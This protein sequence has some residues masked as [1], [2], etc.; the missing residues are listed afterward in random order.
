VNSDPPPQ[1]IPAYQCPPPLR[2]ILLT[3]FSPSD[4]YPPLTSPTR[5]SLSHYHDSPLISQH[6][7]S[8]SPPCHLLLS[9]PSLTYH[10]RFLLPPETCST[11]LLVTPHCYRRLP[12][13]LLSLFL[14]VLSPCPITP[15]LLHLSFPECW[16]PCLPRSLLCCHTIPHGSCSGMVPC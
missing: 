2:V 7:S 15:V 3:S 10:L 5:M 1:L 11:S 6:V 12:L 16:H 9:L 13:N 8:T 4:T 14:H